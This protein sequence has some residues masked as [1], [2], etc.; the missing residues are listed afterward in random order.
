MV[1][2]LEN[3]F[4]MQRLID[5]RINMAIHRN[6]EYSKIDEYNNTRNLV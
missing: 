6:Q 3:D 5:L 2:Y 1:K 4:S